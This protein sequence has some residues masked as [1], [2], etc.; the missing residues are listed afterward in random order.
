MNFPTRWQSAILDALSQDGRASITDLAHRLNVSDETVRRHVKALVDQGAV[1]RVHG[2]V[3]LPGAALE[4]PF[5]RRMKERTSA[6]Q[7]IA[8]AVAE[9]VSDGMTIL[10]DCGSTTAFVARVLLRKRDLTVVTNALEIAHTLIGRCD[11]QV[12]LAGGS[13]RAD[14]AASVGPEAHQ[15]V[16]EFRADLAILSV[17][18]VDA[19]DGIKDFDVDEARIARTMIERSNK[20]IVAADAAKYTAKAPV[21]ICGFDAVDVF[22]TDAAPPDVLAER[23]RA[24]KSEIRVAAVG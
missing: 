23:L 13:I 9:Y 21:C 22:V 24:A 17:G 1:E 18:S 12:Y 2:A 6:K 8:L 14:I 4:P 11:H 3:V 16:S 15:L 10:I 20:V 19:I 5:S 7:A